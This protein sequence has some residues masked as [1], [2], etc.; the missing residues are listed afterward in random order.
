MRLRAFLIE[1]HKQ[2]CGSMRGHTVINN[3]V[4]GARLYSKAGFS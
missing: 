4:S 1:Q 3:I 2:R